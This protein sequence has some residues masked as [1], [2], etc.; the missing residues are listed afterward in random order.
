[1]TAPAVLVA[2]R[3]T[4]STVLCALAMAIAIAIGAAP[5][6]NAS[7]LSCARATADTT[8]TE[9]R[10]VRVYERGGILF[11]CDRRTRRRVRLDVFACEP[12][13]CFVN[14]VGVAGRYVAWETRSVGRDEPSQHLRVAVVPSARLI[15]EELDAPGP[16]TDVV[17]GTNGASAWILDVSRQQAPSYRV[18]AISASGTP[19]QL[20]QSPDIEPAS[21]HRDGR[22]VSWLQAGTRRRT[23]LS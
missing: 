18:L 16:A 21:L 19:R 8:H 2:M 10:S 5:A 9:A 13:A 14:R 7:P 22:S 23:T 1:M 4:F 6:G 12:D 20:A 3:S 17:I 15:A 11:A